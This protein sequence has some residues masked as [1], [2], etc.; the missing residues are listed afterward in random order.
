MKFGGELYLMPGSLPVQAAQFALGVETVG[1]ACDTEYL[2][3]H[4]GGQAAGLCFRQVAQGHV[5]PRVH[6]L[7]PNITDAV[8]RIE[9]LV[10]V[11]ERVH[12][13]H[14]KGLSISAKT[15]LEPR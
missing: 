7:E 13:S 4:G 9:P 1:K 15:I 10:Q 3:P 2:V 14:K 6:G 11:R 5:H 8:S 12:I